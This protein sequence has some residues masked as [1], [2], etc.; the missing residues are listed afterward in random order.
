MLVLRASSISICVLS[1]FF[2]NAESKPLS[3]SNTGCSCS[4][5]CSVSWAGHVQE[6]SGG[7]SKEWCYVEAHC[8]ARGWDWCGDGH[9]FYAQKQEESTD[10]KAQVAWL[11]GQLADTHTQLSDTQS[12]GRLLK[13]KLA[14]AE[15]KEA[16]M[17]L[18]EANTR[19]ELEA[20]QKEMVMM[21]GKQSA[22]AAALKADL[23]QAK[24]KQ[25]ATQKKL[26]E[27]I[28]K[29]SQTEE[30]LHEAQL[31]QT[32]LEKTL[33]A[34]ELKVKDITTKYTDDVQAFLKFR[35]SAAKNLDDAE[36]TL[37]KVEIARRSVQAKLEE[38]EV[39]R[40]DAEHKIVAAV[41]SQQ[42]AEEKQKVAE[43]KQQTAELR[44]FRLAVRGAVRGGTGVVDKQGK[45][46]RWRIR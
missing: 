46:E 5:D 37:K 44:T 17:A 18:K 14:D 25:S 30:S 8:T 20:K 1:L 45:V 6:S 15:T 39:K 28:F 12:D 4:S 19:T 35:T 31:K 27:T 2:Y 13:K 40:A 33:G 16:N 11:K 26:E 9:M 29:E 10:D 7:K 38:T 21:L 24:S 32:A 42:Q 36:S 22:E 34:T 43:G 41:G 3:L 23:A